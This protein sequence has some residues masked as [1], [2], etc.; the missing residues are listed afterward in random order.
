MLLGKTIPKLVTEESHS[1]R[2][3][4]GRKIPKYAEGQLA[5]Q[6][7]FS[8]FS[9]YKLFMYISTSYPRVTYSSTLALYN[10][11][12]AKSQF[13]IE[14]SLTLVEHTTVWS[15]GRIWTVGL[16]CPHYAISYSSPFVSGF[17][18]LCQTSKLCLWDYGCFLW[19]GAIVASWTFAF[20]EVIK[21]MNVVIRNKYDLSVCL[22]LAPLPDP[23]LGKSGEKT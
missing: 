20:P 7:V 14:V 3:N 4:P 9:F 18:A 1:V 21:I 15:F 22:T 10:D 13:Q 5:K 16:W 2:V 19:T 11:T 6:N 12:V 17:L 8:I 23:K